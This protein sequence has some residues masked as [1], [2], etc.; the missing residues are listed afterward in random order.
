[1]VM[2]INQ[3]QPKGG[4]TGPTVTLDAEQFATLVELLTPG[5][6]AAQLMLADYKERQAERESYANSKA[7]TPEDPAKTTPD[8]TEGQTG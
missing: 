7:A 6:E 2:T 1:M 3:L 4:D 5:Y 8:A